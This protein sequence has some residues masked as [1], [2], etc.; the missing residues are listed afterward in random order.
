MPKPH[1]KH[2][3]SSTQPLWRRLLEALLYSSVFISLC[4]L[5]LT[6]ETY[7]LAEL[8][9]SWP[10]AAFVFLA[11]LF[12]YNLSS[13]QSILRRPTQPRDTENTAWAQRH[14]H[15]LAILGLASIAAA[16]VVYVYFR[17]RINV[18]FMLHL[19]IISV[20]YTVPVWYKRRSV[21]PLR[22]IPLLKVFLI[23]YVWATVTALFPLLQADMQVWHQEALWLFLRR[24]L[25]ILALALLFDIRDYTY[26]RDTNT[27]TFPGWAGVHTTKLISL[28]LLVLYVL[29]LLQTE[30]GLVLYALLASAAG[31]AAVVAN[32]STQRSRLYY[33]V[34]ADGS[35]LLHAAL[36][37]AAILSLG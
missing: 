16:A 20:G 9:V 30:S 8:P 4:G 13:I 3:T 28:G 25:F 14:K 27:I 18:L 7:L 22:S 17:L 21:K 15:F 12:T 6:I 10:M 31:A 24:F 37:T 5:G 23:A 32:S 26:D 35:M 33:A 36:V 1:N 2:L 34:F 19:A 11:V 29:V